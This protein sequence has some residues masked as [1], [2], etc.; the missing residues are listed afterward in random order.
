VTR[1]P[2]ATEQLTL[3]A[4]IA[5]T[6]ATA[7]TAYNLTRL[8]R[9]DPAPVPVAG[10]VSV[11]V[12]ARDEE[13]RI[14]ACVRAVLGSTGVPRLELLVLDDGSTDGTTDVVRSV[15]SHDRRLQLITG[16]DQPPPPGW[17][18]K[19]WACAR[20]AEA[21]TGEVLVFLDAD[22]VL[23]PQGLAATVNQLRD[24]GLDL[25][26]PYPRQLADGVL[27]RLVQP[28]LQW[29][30][31]TLVPLGVAERSS[32]ES[33]A[34]A[35]GQLLACSA[36]AYRAVGGHGAVRGAVLDDLEL[37]RA[38][39]RNGFHGG[40]TDGTQVAT[41]HMYDSGEALVDGYTKSLWAAFGS[42]AG[43]AAVVAL[44]CAVYVVPPTVA[45]LGSTARIRWL[46]AAGYGAAVVGRILVARRTG[47]RALPDTL[48]HPAS[49]VAF[50]ALVARSWRRR[51]NGQLTWRRRLIP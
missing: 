34:V 48:A 49:V 41:C 3:A 45:L 35:N 33:L 40:V 4:T 36:A 13:P 51:R 7:H 42:P 43:A 44:L 27:Q 25:V 16:P 31:L 26:S 37:L 29:S 46:G 32:R 38:F 28:L 22:V 1:K 5:A 30:W 21:A 18:G 24:S 6:I 2:R 19:P 47:Q 9:P 12:P 39:Q 10:T 20:L 15:G 17:L 14:G 50:S 23:A 11:L 8:R